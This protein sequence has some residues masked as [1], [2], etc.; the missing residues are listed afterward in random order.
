VEV[1]A[2]SKSNIIVI[3]CDRGAVALERKVSVAC[4]T[5]DQRALDCA[6]C[7]TKSFVG[8]WLGT[9]GHDTVLVNA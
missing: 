3:Q 1:L 7:A 5:C 8:K 6:R 2:L 9:A 4:I